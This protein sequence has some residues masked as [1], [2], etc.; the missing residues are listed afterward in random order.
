[1][2]NSQ[3]RRNAQSRSHMAKFLTQQNSVHWYPICSRYRIALRHCQIG[4]PLFDISAHNS[5]S[6]PSLTSKR[7][8]LTDLSPQKSQSQ[9]HLTPNLKATYS[10]TRKSMYFR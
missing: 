7:Q 6:S 8:K 5:Y 1:M 10:G 4:G 3:A 2:Y 9:C